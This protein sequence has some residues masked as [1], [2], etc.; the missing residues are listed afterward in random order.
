MLRNRLT[1]GVKSSACRLLKLMIVTVN[2]WR[3]WT[4]RMQAHIICTTHTQ[5]YTEI[6]RCLGIYVMRWVFLVARQNFFCRTTR[7]FVTR[8]I[9][10]SCNKFICCATSLSVTWRV[11]LW[12]DKSIC[13]MTSF[14]LLLLLL[15]LLASPGNQVGCGTSTDIISLPNFQPAPPS[16]GRI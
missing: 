1:S 7:L 10:W 13:C 6:S 14:V 2:E 5:I 9:Y 15:L 12:C 8:R 4:H 11:Y 16:D 3:H